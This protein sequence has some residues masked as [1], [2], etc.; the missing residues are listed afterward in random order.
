MSNPYQSPQIVAEAALTDANSVDREKLR[1]V[2]KY[3]QWVLYTLLA[4]IVINLMAMST[5]GGGTAVSLALG[6]LALVI[7]VISMFAVFR[8]ANELYNIAVGIVCAVLMIVPCVSLLTLLIVN[9][10][11][12]TFL[13]QRGIKVGFMGVNP[14]TI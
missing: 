11:A 12:T 5:R 9:G 2:A 1:R 7:V 13:Q 10:K 3:Q 14:N 6:G 4:N 8:L